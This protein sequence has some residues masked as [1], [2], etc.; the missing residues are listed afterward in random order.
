MENSTI[1][2]VFQSGFAGDKQQESSGQIAPVTR[3][4]GRNKEYAPWGST[5]DLP[6]QLI[7]VVERSAIMPG[8]IE[9][10]EGVLF[11]NGLGV[12]QTSWDEKKKQV[13]INQIWDEDIQNWL[14][15]SLAHEYILNTLPDFL[16]TGNGFVQALFSQG[17]KNA[18]K[19]ITRFAHTDCT[20]CRLEIMTK[21]QID[22][23]YISN[24]FGRRQ[25][26]NVSTV[27]QLTERIENFKRGKE[28]YSHDRCM[29]H[30]RRKKAGRKYYGMPVW[31]SEETKLV[32]ES[33]TDMFK[34]QKGS[35]KNEIRAKYHILIWQD[36]FKQKYPEPEHNEDFRQKKK[37][38]LVQS[39]H[40]NLTKPE[41]AG[42]AIWSDFIFDQRSGE[43]KS[44]IIIK[45]VEEGKGNADVYLKSRD[46]AVAMLAMATNTNPGLADLI[47]SGKLGSDTGSAVRESYNVLSKTKTKINRML[48]LQPINEAIKYNWPE[49]KN[50]FVDFIGFELV[51]TDEKKE[52][53]QT[54]MKPNQAG[55]GKD[56]SGQTT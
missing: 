50:I 14:E 24:T 11:G 30:I 22:N 21:G 8:L 9:F 15:T 52:G 41:N 12:F 47:I 55:P 51:T 48:L 5:D 26:E 45:P 37:E 3:E 53:V 46:Q 27:T 2:V 23:T 39:V 35:L 44:G 6:N 31:W 36:Y 54:E 13:V 18:K 16:S 38:E 7:E 29:F 17:S 20:D 19:Q 40:D 32:M 43:P 28:K 25:I 56:S 4:D 1:E 33:T 49:K 10:W 42:K 34:L